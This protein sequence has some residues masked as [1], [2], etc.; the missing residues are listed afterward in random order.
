MT[1]APNCAPGTADAVSG[2]TPPNSI[3]MK[4]FLEL[5]RSKLYRSHKVSVASALSAEISA[6]L[7][8]P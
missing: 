6:R 3:V 2:T 1:L 7:P 5:L 4:L 8:S